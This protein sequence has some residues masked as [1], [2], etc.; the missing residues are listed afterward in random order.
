M[1]KQYLILNKCHYIDQRNLYQNK[2]NAPSK[3]LNIFVC[4]KDK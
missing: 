1:K 2:R 4:I 3:Y